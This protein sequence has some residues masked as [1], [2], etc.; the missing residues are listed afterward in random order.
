ML[1]NLPVLILIG[2]VFVAILVAIVQWVWNSTLCTIFQIRTI[3][4]WEAFKIMLLSS[5]LFG[6]LS[7]PFHLS[8]STT[9]E[10]TTQ[11][12]GIGNK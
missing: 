9:E 3:S 6:G 11:S 12:F 10:N 8:T 4:F 1:N 5:I 7:L 2:I